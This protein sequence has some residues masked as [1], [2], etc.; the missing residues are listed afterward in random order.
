[1]RQLFNIQNEYAAL[2]TV[3]L[4][5]AQGI[6]PDPDHE[7][8]A[9][10]PATSQLYTQPD[11]AMT[12]QDFSGVLEC[13][14]KLGIEVMQPDLVESS[15]V[16]DQTCPR[17]I[18]FV[19]DSIYFKANSRYTSR[20]LEHRGIEH[21]LSTFSHQHQVDMPQDI[22]L[23]GG[24]VVL[25]PGKVFVGLGARSTRTGILWLA[26]QLKH[27]E[28]DREIIIVPHDVL[29]LDC[30][31]NVVG[32]NLAL[33]CNQATGNFSD[34]N[35]NAIEIDFETILVNRKEQAALATNVLV[36]GPGEIF[37]R[38]HFHCDKVNDQIEK[39]YKFIVHRLPFD[40]VPAI[41]GSFRCA[42]LP[43]YRS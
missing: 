36:I 25:A 9:G 29:H 21:L 6:K 33:W 19:I 22:F 18:G 38:N 24:D 20:N 4:G 5:T 17:D 42:T 11:P 8:Q 30:C 35:G 12:E 16:T 26:D 3:I 32:P 27:H 28:I 39:K 14:E 7:L 10:L 43:L 34:I 37:A 23:E 1:M 41:G 40:C 13:M 2:Q 15:Q 31:W